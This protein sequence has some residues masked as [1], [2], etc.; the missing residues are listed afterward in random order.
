MAALLRNKN[1]DVQEIAA[2]HDLRRASNSALDALEALFALN[3]CTAGQ[4][5]RQGLP[6]SIFVIKKHCLQLSVQTHACIRQLTAITGP[7][8][9]NTSLRILLAEQ[10]Q[11]LSLLLESAPKS[12]QDTLI[13]PLVADQDQQLCHHPSQEKDGPHTLCQAG[14]NS[15]SQPQAFI[16]TRAA[17]Q[18][19]LHKLYPRI[20][21]ALQQLDTANM[22]MLVAVSSTIQRLI[23]ESPLPAALERSLVRQWQHLDPQQKK[24]QPFSLHPQVHSEDGCRSSFAGLC[25]AVEAVD[26]NSLTQGYMHLLASLY[27]PQSLAYMQA[28]GLRH[29]HTELTVL[30]QPAGRPP[31]PALACRS[32][33]SQGAKISTTSTI[34]VHT[35]TQQVTPDPGADI[36]YLQGECGAPGSAAGTVHIIHSLAD[37]TDLPEQAV[38]LVR[39]ARME[40][41]PLLSKVV[42]LVVEEDASAH[43][44]LTL[45]REFCLPVVFSV[46]GAG[47]ALHN[48]MSV[49]VDATRG[50]VFPGSMPSTAVLQ[51]APLASPNTD[52]PVE[53][54]L[55]EI[56]TLTGAQR[57]AAPKLPALLSTQTNGA[58]TTEYGS[59]L[60]IVH[61]CRFK[62]TQEIL[63]RYTQGYARL[64]VPPLQFS[65]Y[66]L[67]LDVSNGNN[68]TCS[69]NTSDPDLNNIS[70]QPMRILGQAMAAGLQHLQGR[71]TELATCKQ[72]NSILLGDKYCTV[73][74]VCPG[75]CLYIDAD[76]GEQPQAAHIIF[77]LQH[78]GRNSTTHLHILASYLGKHNIPIQLTGQYLNVVLTERNRQDFA[79]HLH[80]L[81]SAC[82]QT[83][84]YS[85]EIIDPGLAP[86]DYKKYKS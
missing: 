55:R 76:M 49:G 83:L 7:G 30:C 38:A 31:I 53:K 44:L 19:V 14:G 20:N 15:V 39:Q 26:Y 60:D 71:L 34:E 66:T 4:T 48:G 50:I 37:G 72:K 62:A 79:R 78:K 9:D 21:H 63:R 17:A 56:C 1:K 43:P 2:F 24:S 74:I 65:A 36:P 32:D 46:A 77:L 67:D 29:E 47:C 8:E 35:H 23:L 22:A 81:G 84:A 86:S 61:L 41:T 68:D 57:I 42:A 70:S 80:L 82:V 18:L 10:V 6:P 5:R 3:I 28:K 40:W 69:T 25:P 11:A 27:S 64:F 85:S 59:M 51:A 52:S 54:I 33:F 13:L 12:G 16:I 75:F 73:Q 45:A 58:N